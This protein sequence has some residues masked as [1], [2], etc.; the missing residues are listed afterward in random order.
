MI[1]V[2]LEEV[3]ISI[4]LDNIDVLSLGISKVYTTDISNGIFITIKL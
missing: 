2:R 1:I 4:Y 3:Y